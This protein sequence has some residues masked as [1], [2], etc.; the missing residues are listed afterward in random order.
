M[1]GSIFQYLTLLEIFETFRW[2]S[3][4]SLPLSLGRERVGYKIISSFQL[5]LTYLR[6]LPGHDEV[7]QSSHLPAS[8][9]RRIVPLGDGKQWVV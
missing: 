4:P 3:D 5:R 7:I 2:I 6:Y 1:L 8:F 9:W